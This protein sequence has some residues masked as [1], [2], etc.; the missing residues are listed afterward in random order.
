MADTLKQ[1]GE[2]TDINYTELMDGQSIVS[3]TGSQ[4]AVIKDISIDNPKARNIDVSLTSKNGTKIATTKNK[5]DTLTGNLILDNSQSLYLSST[6]NCAITDFRARGWGEGNNRSENKVY[7]WGNPG[8][9]F[10][11][12]WTWDG[13]FGTPNVNTSTSSLSAKHIGINLQN[14]SNGFEANGYWYWHHL[15]TGGSY[16]TA[17]MCRTD[18]VEGT[19]GAGSTVTQ[20]GDGKAYVMAY[21]GSRYIYTMEQSGTTIRK[22]DTNT[23]GTS[24][25]YTSITVLQPDSDSNAQTVSFGLYNCGFYFRDGYLFVNSNGYNDG[26]T[27]PTAPFK[28]RIIDVSTGKSRLVYDPGLDDANDFASVARDGYRRAMGLVRD[29]NGVYWA[30]LGQTKYYNSNNDG[31]RVWG[32]SLGIN[33]ATDFLANGKNYGETF[34]YKIADYNS[35]NNM[36]QRIRQNMIQCGQAFGN[37]CGAIMYTPG[38]DKYLYTYTKEYSTQTNTNTNGIE[39]GWHRVTFDFDNAT[40]GADKFMSMT[41][42]TNPSEVWSFTGWVDA[43]VAKSSFGTVKA[44][45]AGVLVT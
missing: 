14:P 6:D 9:Q 24:D 19:T 37:S 12:G 13:N 17:R 32:C 35:D 4:K 7:K 40:A 44:R 38:M 28:P 36:R 39:G 20:Y 22:Y 10:N 29:S 26:S 31:N 23:L 30:F 21:D 8:V 18:I 15:R 16:N 1:F 25:T 43:D 3:T 33:P 5:I 11:P 45:T 2:D 34:D 41:S 27:A 42:S